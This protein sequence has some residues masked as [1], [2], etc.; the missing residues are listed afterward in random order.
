MRKMIDSLSRRQVSMLR[1]GDTVTLTTQLLLIAPTTE[2]NG[3]RFDASLSSL[4]A[5]RICCLVTETDGSAGNQQWQIACIDQPAVDQF[6]CSM[7]AAGAC[8]CVGQGRCSAA[9]SYALRKYEGLY[10]W[11][12]VDW[13]PRILG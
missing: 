2:V 10:F 13:L 11:V 3:S 8:A 12:D 7:L 1:A 9:L 6:A 4:V 5:D